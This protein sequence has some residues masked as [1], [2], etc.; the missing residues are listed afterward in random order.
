MKEG[1]NPHCRRT[2]LKEKIREAIRQGIISRV[3]SFQLADLIKESGEGNIC[4]YLLN[5]KQN[6]TYRASISHSA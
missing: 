2:L 4:L 1:P 3:I 5:C 6:I